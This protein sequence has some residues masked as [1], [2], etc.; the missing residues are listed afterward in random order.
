MKNI[1]KITLTVFAI[2]G[3]Y[4]VITGFTKEEQEVKPQ[5]FYGT[6]ESHVWTTAGKFS[7]RV[8]FLNKITGE[9]RMAKSSGYTVIKEKD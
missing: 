1:K 8:I 3:F 4:A 9:I 2:I 7:D 5:T 6:P